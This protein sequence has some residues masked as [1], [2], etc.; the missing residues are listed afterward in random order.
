MINRQRTT[1][2]RAPRMLSPEQ[3]EELR[4]ALLGP[5]PDGAVAVAGTRCRGLDGGETR[6]TSGYATWLGVKP[7]TLRSWERSWAPVDPQQAAQWHKALAEAAADRREQ[8][9]REGLLTEQIDA[10]TF[11]AA[12]AVLSSLTAETTAPRGA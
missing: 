4:A 12:I 3:Q 8:L 2:W 11:A 9:H 7:D 6:P 5:T 10:S 1:S